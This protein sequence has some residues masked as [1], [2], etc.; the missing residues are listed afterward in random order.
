MAAPACR[1]DRVPHLPVIPEPLA[2]AG[3]GA[4]ARLLDS[5]THR[6]PLGHGCYGRRAPSHASTRVPCREKHLLQAA[7]LPRTWVSHHGCASR[8]RQ[9]I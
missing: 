7:S 9:L 1:Q 5:P 4:A 6:P 8:I 2:A 3:P